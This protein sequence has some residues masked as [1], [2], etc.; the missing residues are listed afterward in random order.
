[1]CS[2]T[3]ATSSQQDTGCAFG[4]SGL[5]G[6]FLSGGSTYGAAFGGGMGS[7]GSGS[8]GNTSSIGSARFALN[9]RD[10][11][12]AAA[13]MGSNWNAWLSLS[14]S[15][16]AYKFQ[17]L[18]SSGHVNLSLI[19]I[20]YSFANNLTAGVAVGWDQ[21]RVGTSFNGGS[22]NAD[23][24]MVAPYL[25][26]RFTPAWS[27]DA[28]LGFGHSNI[29]QVDNST[30]GGI[31]GNYGDDRFLGSLSLAY[32]KMLG[33]WIFTGRGSYLGSQDRFSQFT[34]SNGTAIGSATNHNTQLRAGGQAMYNGGVVL[35]YVGV[36]YFNYV[37][38]ANQ[39]AVGGSTPA[40]DRDGFQLQGGIQFAPRGM[41][42]GGIMAATDVGRSQ[43]RNDL[44][45]GNIGIRF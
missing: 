1:M 37:Q 4:S 27:V 31:T 22:L 38:Q 11:G 9:T 7:G 25:S 17:P 21:T 32:T 13:G 29:S 8:S 5:Q 28:T 42:Y 6:V 43:I 3:S 44:I 18:Q 19:G 23:G 15:D 10:T 2:G 30:P 39:A 33:K 12:K 16:L 36:Y 34:L 14:Y 40:N 45:M 20:D 35:P 41:V 26:W 24:Y